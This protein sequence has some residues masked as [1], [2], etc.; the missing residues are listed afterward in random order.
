MTSRPENSGHRECHRL[1]VL[2][3][4]G[5]VG[6]ACCVASSLEHGALWGARVVA[7]ALNDELEHRRGTVLASW[8]APY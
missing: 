8:G 5:L 2:A 7:V 6:A 4:S 1:K 3:L